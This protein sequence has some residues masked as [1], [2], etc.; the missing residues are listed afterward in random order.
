MNLKWVEEKEN[1]LPYKQNQGSY[2]LKMPLHIYFFFTHSFSNIY[3][4]LK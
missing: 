3:L 1:V 2:N 4:E